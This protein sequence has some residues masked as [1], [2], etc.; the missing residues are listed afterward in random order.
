MNSIQIRADEK[1]KISFKKETSNTIDFGSRLSFYIKSKIEYVVFNLEGYLL[2]IRF[3]LDTGTGEIRNLIR[4]SG[5]GQLSAIYNMFY[6][7]DWGLDKSR[8]KAADEEVRAWP[9]V[10]GE[11]IRMSGQFSTM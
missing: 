3:D 9:W 2:V 4:L 5:F 6:T 8:S 7:W 1:V 11:Q 10:S